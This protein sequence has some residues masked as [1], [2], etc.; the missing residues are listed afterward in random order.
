MSLRKRRTD[1]EIAARVK[2]LKVDPDR[3]YRENP[4][5]RF[6]FQPKDKKTSEAQNLD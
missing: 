3:F 2:L 1:A 6:G 5:V 4:R